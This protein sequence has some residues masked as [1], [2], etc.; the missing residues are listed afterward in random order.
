MKIICVNKIL[1]GVTAIIFEG[2]LSSVAQDYT[3]YLT[4]SKNV[5]IRNITKNMGMICTL[6]SMDVEAN[7]TAHIIFLGTYNYAES[8]DGVTTDIFYT[9]NKSGDFFDPIKITATPK[10]G[11]VSRYYSKEAT[12]AVDNEGYAHV[13]F[14][15]A[16]DQIIYGYD[17]LYYATNKNK[18]IKDAVVLDQNKGLH[19][20]IDIDD[21]GNV[22]ILCDFWNANIHYM[23][24]TNEI[25]SKPISINGPFPFAR[26]PAYFVVDKKGILHIVYQ[27]ESPYG[28]GGDV[29]Y[30]NNKSGVFNTFWLTRGKEIDSYNGLYDTS[31]R[32]WYEEDPSIDIDENNDPHILFNKTYVVGPWRNYYYRIINNNKQVSTSNQGGKI[33]I[34]KNNKVHM[35]NAKTYTTNYYGNFKSYTIMTSDLVGTS[36][37][38]QFG[39]SDDNKVHFV[40]HYPKAPIFGGNPNIYYGSFIINELITEIET[41]HSDV[42]Y[43]F[44]LSQNYPNPFNQATMIRYSIP[45]QGNVLIEVYNIHGTRVAELK[46]DLEN[47]GNYSVNWNG[48]NS[49]NQS[50]SSGI[51]LCRIQAGKYQK[52][53]RMLLLK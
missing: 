6:P 28:I 24:K 41:S 22:Y 44:T 50:V 11:D 3:D 9:N 31:D 29:V 45:E 7:G 46:N 30:I 51:Y 17:P 34:D 1:L 37:T 4:I 53:I 38:R 27:A 23:K 32:G 16:V 2:T 5:K 25:W 12:I 14:H 35:Y 33:I 49:M 26:L 10:I 36:D 52:T 15:R 8:P 43:K 39:V 47:A 40:I 21:F 13:V 42:Q 19:T 48:K 18:N 20:E